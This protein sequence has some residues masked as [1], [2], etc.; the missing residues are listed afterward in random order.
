MNLTPKQFA[1]ICLISGALSIIHAV[2]TGDRGLVAPLIIGAVV[3][4]VSAIIIY[5]RHE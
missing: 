5:M 1:V 2:L 4:M 3:G